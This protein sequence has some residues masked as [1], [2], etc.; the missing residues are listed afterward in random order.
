MKVRDKE[1]GLGEKRLMPLEIGNAIVA[2]GVKPS[3]VLENGIE[4]YEVP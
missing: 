3:H 2:A 1:A 4:I